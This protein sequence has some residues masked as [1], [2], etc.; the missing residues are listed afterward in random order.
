MN[1]QPLSRVN[2]KAGFH[3][4]LGTADAH[5][6][7]DLYHLVQRVIGLAAYGE[8]GWAH[9]YGSILSTSPVPAFAMYRAIESERAKRSILLAGAKVSV[10]T[11]DYNILSSVIKAVTPVFKVRHKFAHHLWGHAHE[12]PD[13]LLLAE[14]EV[15]IHEPVMYGLES[16]RLHRL[17]LPFEVVAERGVNLDYSRIMVWSRDA[18]NEAVKEMTSAVNCINKCSEIF[19]PNLPDR[20]RNEARISLLQWPRYETAFAQISTKSP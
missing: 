15:L 12:L 16:V 6:H 8:A 1:P 3:S 14:P 18:L 5:L 11:Y 7:P 19:L 17:G 13:A 10:S 20:V 4:E 2:P 9:I